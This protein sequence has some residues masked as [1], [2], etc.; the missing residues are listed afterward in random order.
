MHYISLLFRDKLLDRVAQ[1]IDEVEY[2]SHKL[3]IIVLSTDERQELESGL[4]ED[5]ITFINVSKLLSKKLVSLSINERICQIEDLFVDVAA[6][7]GKDKWL[8]KLDIFCEPSLQ[9]DILSLLKWLSKSQ[10]IVAIWPGC[11]EGSSLVYA[12]PGSQDYRTY[13]LNEL[14]NI[15][16]INACNGVIK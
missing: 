3:A 11:I 10:L 6:D 15:Q 12:K 14:K 7:C 2:Y 5:G 4:I 1:A 13:S 8:T 9:T 16:V